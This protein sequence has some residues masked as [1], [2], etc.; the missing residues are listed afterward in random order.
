MQF[1][2]KNL[3]LKCFV[4]CSYAVA[5]IGRVLFLLLFLL[6][7]LNFVWRADGKFHE[8]LSCSVQN[9]VLNLNS[10]F[11]I[12]IACNGRKN[13]QY[14]FIPDNKK[15]DGGGQK[16]FFPKKFHEN[17]KWFDHMIQCR[18]FA[19][20]PHK[21]FFFW[22][23][24]LEYEHWA[25]IHCPEISN[26]AELFAP[27]RLAVWIDVYWANCEQNSSKNLKGLSS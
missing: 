17:Y 26:C 22:F 4:F 10:E 11:R 13:E 16:L 15:L 20:S 12:V 23:W 2:W 7:C 3:M 9:D 14:I 27:R 24:L 21:V 18:V 5:R 25:F 6:Y 19:C 8:R 1:N